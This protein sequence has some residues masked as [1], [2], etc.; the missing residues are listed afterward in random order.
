MN[1]AALIAVLLELF[2]PLIRA[3]LE[4]LFRKAEPKLGV[5]PAG[6]VVHD[7]EITELFAAARAQM[8]WRQWLWRRGALAACER[9]A[10]RRAA[11]VRNAMASGAPIVMT[12][13]DAVEIAAAL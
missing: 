1:W 4:E 3:W 8:T 9:V 10:L 2:G 7:A 11:S 12:T 5:Y 6:A 13:A